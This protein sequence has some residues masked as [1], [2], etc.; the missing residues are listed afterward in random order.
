MRKLTLFALLLGAL[1]GLGLSGTAPAQASLSSGL[2]AG[3]V[4]TPVISTQAYTAQSPERTVLVVGDSITVRSYKALATAL[5]GRR[6]AVNAHSG[7]NTRLSIDSLLAQMKGLPDEA[8]PADLLMA[9]GTND[10]FAPGAMRA[11]VARLLSVVPAHVRVHWV[12]VYAARPA[13]LLADRHNSY[14][15]NQS[16][17][18]GC[19]AAVPA[20]R[21]TL[22]TW[23]SFIAGSPYR[24]RT[25]IDS[26]GVHPTVAGQADWGKLL[27]AA[28]PIGV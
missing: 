11:Q 8:W 1:F 28:V 20:G 15:V 26:G 3:P 23:G 25:D 18:A 16:I 22:V 12:T 9:T 4:G 2:P 19:K 21:C 24:M 10:I 5:G 6:L 14:L 13:Y 27:A 17:V 7:R